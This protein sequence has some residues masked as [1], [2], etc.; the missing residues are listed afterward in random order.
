MAKTLRLPSD[1]PVRDF[2]TAVGSAEEVHGTASTAAVAGGLDASLL[3]RVATRATTNSDSRHTRTGV[4]EAAAAFAG[5]QRQLIETIE[6]ETSLRIFVA[7]SMPQQSEAQ[8][9]E[10]QV[11]IQLA[12][13]AAADVRWK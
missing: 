10:R 3:L 12:L 5:V 4:Q 13:R 1:M 11:A 2:I 8:R 6:T 9:S 7:Q